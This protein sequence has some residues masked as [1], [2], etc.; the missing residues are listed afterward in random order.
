MKTNIKQDRK[1]I[2][3]IIENNLSLMYSDKR[4]IQEVADAILVYMIDK[5]KTKSENL[6]YILHSLDWIKILNNAVNN[7]KSSWNFQGFGNPVIEWRNASDEICMAL[8]NELEDKQILED[9]YSRLRKFIKETNINKLLKD[10]EKAILESEKADNK[11]KRL[12]RDE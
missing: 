3:K 6:R 8:I 5:K 12:L 7:R 10:A 4:A 1:A 9:T 11:V 2:A